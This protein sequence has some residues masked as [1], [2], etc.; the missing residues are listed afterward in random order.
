MGDYF[1]WN[2][3]DVVQT[4]LM[5]TCLGAL[6]KREINSVLKHCKF[7]IGETK[8]RVLFSVGDRC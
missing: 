2:G 3:R 4:D 6:F 8:E 1:F 5:G 7:E